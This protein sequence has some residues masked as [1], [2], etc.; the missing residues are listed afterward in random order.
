M[1]KLVQKRE[2]LE[3]LKIKFLFLI[4]NV[5]KLY[6]NPNALYFCRALYFS[7]PLYK[8]VDSPFK[9]FF[10]CFIEL[11]Y[12]NEILKPST[13]LKTIIARVFDFGPCS[14]APTTCFII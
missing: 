5:W 11:I 6:L 14:P 1:V 3:T 4:F 12:A 7:P 2:Y 8:L 13:I 10:R 9:Q